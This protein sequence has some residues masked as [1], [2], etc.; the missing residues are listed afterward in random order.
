MNYWSQNVTAYPKAIWLKVC[1]DEEG[2]QD[3][4]V[5]FD[6]F[7][8]FG[9]MDGM[10]NVTCRPGGGPVDDNDNRRADEN[11]IQRAFFTSYGKNRT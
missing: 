8:V 3:I 1:F 5:A 10:K 2:N 9:W 11:R 4:P 6:E 7:A